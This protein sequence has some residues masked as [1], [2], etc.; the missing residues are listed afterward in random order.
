M[1]YVVVFYDFTM[2]ELKRTGAWDKKLNGLRLWKTDNGAL[3]YC[4]E[5]PGYL[6]TS[7]GYGR[8]RDH[9]VQIDGSNARHSLR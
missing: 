5:G 7:M 4:P 3:L 8:I 1:G 9:L 6:G 2:G